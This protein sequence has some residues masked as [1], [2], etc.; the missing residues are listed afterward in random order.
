MR[1]DSVAMASLRIVLRAG[2]RSLR[3]HG[4]NLRHVLVVGE[5]IVM[6]RLIERLDSY[7]ELGLRV[8]GVITDELAGSSLIRGKKVLVRV[9]FNVPLTK[10]GGVSDDRRIR[11]A[12]PT[13]NYALEQGASLVL[14]SHLGRPTGKPEEDAAFRMDRVAAKLQEV[15]GRPVAKVNGRAARPTLLATLPPPT[16]AKVVLSP[17]RIT[18]LV[19]VPRALAPVVGASAATIKT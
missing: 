12:L 14:V 1:T 8:L 2:L 10:D 3:T 17:P 5:G 15:L 18:L 6:E 16:T 7:P 11:A 9:D 19:A 13:L 4:F